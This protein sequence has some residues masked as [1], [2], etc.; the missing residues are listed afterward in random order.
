MEFLPLAV[1]PAGSLANSVVT[2]VWLGV[3]VVGFFNLRF[4]W[5]LSGLVVP[6]YLAPLLIAKPWAAVAI[7]SEGVVTYLLV[8]L[9][10]ERVMRWLGLAG[11]FGRDRFFAMVLVSILV[12]ILFDGWLFPLLGEWVNATFQLQFDYRYNLHSFGLIIVSLIANQFW[13]SGLVRGIPPFVITLTLTWLFT[14]YGLMELTNFS[15]SNLSYMYEDVAASML[16][17]PKSYIILITAAFIASRM[18]LLYGWDFNGILIP[19]LLALQWYQPEK[20]LV[21]FAEA[22]I[23]LMFA[24]L[25]L[26]LPRYQGMTMEGARKMMLFFNISFAWKMALGLFLVRFFP[27]VKVTDYFAFGY[28]LS[29]LMAVK[30][31]DK[32]IVARLTRATLQTSLVAVV[33]ATVIG[34]LLTLLPLPTT[35]VG[36]DTPALEA[37]LETGAQRMKVSRLLEAIQQEKLAIH[38]QRREPQPYLPPLPREADL[39]SEGIRRLN[40]YVRTGDPERLEEGRSLLLQI[41][42]HLQRLEGD[43]L[44]LSEGIPRRGWGSYLLNLNPQSRLVV[45][46]PSP[47]EERST[48]EAALWLYRQSGARAYAMAGAA[49]TAFADG[50]ADPLR[51]RQTPFHLFHREMGGRDVV[52]I[53]A[54]TGV[55]ARAL[56]G[57]RSDE[58]IDALATVRGDFWIQREL[59]QG[60]D[61]VAL[62]ELVPQLSFQWRASPLVNIQRE[63]TLGGFA[64][65]FLTEDGLRQLLL[66]ATQ[67][68]NEPQLLVA[69]QRIDGYIQQWLF[70]SKE[71]IAPRGSDLDLPPQPGDLLHWDEEIITP[72]LATARNEQG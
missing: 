17:S 29:T 56:A 70:Q 35:W 43:H 1:F 23:I 24:I 30:M 72:L 20:I 13:K 66:H 44:L 21:S 40:R 5:V 63:E 7:C 39:F 18:N 38:Q 2:T 14:R 65:L 36:G 26:K 71:A 67:R 52:Q 19:S 68:R 34:F 28:M 42:Y 58:G 64:E 46:V 9:Y 37:A 25:L 61:L 3:L 60:I 15:I 12:R 47:L 62:K 31:H 45:E 49:R 27:T 50:S 41:G 22:L 4:G 8:W 32:E 16:A 69:D 59:P 55:A 10:S 11:F 33:G 57:V 6:G 53:R 51:S 48:A 54:L